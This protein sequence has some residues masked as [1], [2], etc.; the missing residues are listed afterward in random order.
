MGELH[1]I[2]YL[3]YYKFSCCSGAKPD[4][5]PKSTLTAQSLCLQIPDSFNNSL[6]DE[7]V[8]TIIFDF[9]DAKSMYEASKL[10]RSFRDALIPRQKKVT[11]AGWIPLL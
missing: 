8:T 3:E 1:W 10:S 5:I 11:M 9:L 6:L 7:H 2:M 4:R